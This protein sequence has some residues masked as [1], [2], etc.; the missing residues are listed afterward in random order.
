M[1]TFN[2]PGFGVKS[3][4]WSF[5]QPAQVNSSEWSGT[6]TVVSNP[7][8]GK[9]SAKVDLSTQQGDGAF[10]AAR[11]FFTQLKGQLN[12]FHLP[13]VEAP[14]NSNTGVTVAT[15]AAQGA[16]SIALTGLTDALVIGN[17]I[18]VNGQ[19]LSLT[20]VGSLVAG[21]QT[22]GFMPALRAQATATTA[23]QTAKPYA[24]VALTDSSFTWDIGS[25]RRYGLSFTVEEAV[26]ETDGASPD[27]DTWN[28]TFTSSPSVPVAALAIGL[29]AT[30]SALSI[31]TGTDLVQTSGYSAVG[32]GHAIYVADAAVDGTYVSTY[33][34]AA[35]ITA[36]GRGFR[37]SYEQFHN[38]QQFG[39]LA[40][41][42]TDDAAAFLAARTWLQSIQFDPSSGGYYTGSPH[43][44][45]L[46]N[47]YLNMAGAGEI[48]LEFFAGTQ[49]IGHGAGRSGPSGGAASQLRF[50]AGSHGV[51]AQGA[52][53]S[54]VT[55][56][57][58]STH[59]GVPGFTMRGVKIKLACSGTEGEYHGFIPRV[60]SWLDD[61]YIV[62]CPGE[63]VKGWAGNVTGLGSVGGNLSTSHFR[64]VKVEG[65]RGGFDFRG[66]DANLITLINC[67]GYQNRHFG[68]LDDNGAGSN[69][70]IGPHCASNGVVTGT[71]P[72]TQCSYSGNRYA[73]K[74]G[75]D[76]TVAPS[77]TTADTVNW[78]YIEAGGAISNLIPAWVSTPNTFRAGGDYL[79]LNSAGVH[80]I[81]P[82]SEGGGFSQ[83]NSNTLIEH[84]TIAIQYFRGGNRL[85]AN[86]SGLTLVPYLGGNLNLQPTNGSAGLWIL[87]L[88]GTATAYVDY[89][90]GLG[91]QIKMGAGGLY[92]RDASGIVGHFD[93][94]GF[95]YDSSGNK[96][97]GA[98]QTGWTAATGTPARGAFAAA[99]AGTASVGYTQSELQGALNRIAAL[100]A[101]LIAAE[102]DLR[103]FGVIN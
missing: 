64:G 44:D 35:F 89:T 38:P 70:N 90:T 61:V 96:V 14:Q 25:W 23:A 18:T 8:H 77:G 50:A 54:G 56:V 71:W 85:T 68:F 6:R 92:L 76:F 103:S 33:P 10:R 97:V 43:L 91:W 29:F 22:V 28:A 9:W 88:A 48:G 100:E 13:A 60:V 47:Y 30:A 11:A 74:W 95:Y 83:F 1:S 16:V 7:W 59:R 42:T 66:G 51:I 2:W 17:M 21:A 49:I 58:V 62:D 80:L 36:N 31:P 41:D 69:I 73:A 19:L 94:S 3:V 67:E 99:A 84:G 37:L 79:T 55:T 34:R 101:R 12:T 4:S 26:G 32:T 52:N 98:R 39:A 24:L 53:T 65:C 15:T 20:S 75:G 72:Q 5:D 45:L 81:S 102:A 27:G 40:D 82:Y 46:G 57:D 86:S 78:I 63:G 87:D 93:S